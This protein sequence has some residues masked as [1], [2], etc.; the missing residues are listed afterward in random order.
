MA[1]LSVERARVGKKRL[2]VIA[3]TLDAKRLRNSEL[4]A[5]PPET[6]IVRQPVSAAASSVRVTRS[7]T[8]AD[9]KLEITESVRGLQRGSR[10]EAF[11]R[12]SRRAFFL[13]SISSANS[14]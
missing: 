2:T 5:T 13:A 9:W 14:G 8:T 12:P 1:A 4:A 11:R 3:A 10:S 6:R 7:W